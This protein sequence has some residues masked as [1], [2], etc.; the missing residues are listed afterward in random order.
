[1][2]DLVK[3]LKEDGKTND[4]TFQASREIER[5]QAANETLAAACLEFVRKVDDGKAR[6]KKSYAQMKEALT[7][8]GYRF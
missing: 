6:S 3:R 7:A 1:M 8:A 4:L 2:D 5:L